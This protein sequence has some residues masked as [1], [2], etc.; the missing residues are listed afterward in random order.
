MPDPRAGSATHVG[1]RRPRNED[2]LLL[3]PEAGLW[4]V[5]DGMGGHGGGDVASGLVVA[6]LAALPVEPTAEA[7][8]AA[9]ERAVI[10]AH[11]D[12]RA[13]AARE[14]MSLIGTTLVALILHDAHYAC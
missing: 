3:R 6:A 9:V 10:A 1:L 14:N 12:M 11:R 5:A 7:R 4:A 2:S 8:L 13:H